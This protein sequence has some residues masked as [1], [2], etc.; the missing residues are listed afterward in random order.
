MVEQK[1]QLGRHYQK[2]K[3]LIYNAEDMDHGAATLGVDLAKSLRK[4]TANSRMGL[5]NACRLPSENSQSA[6]RVLSVP[7]KG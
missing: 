7:A 2:W 4:S 6:L 1:E 5:G 3:S